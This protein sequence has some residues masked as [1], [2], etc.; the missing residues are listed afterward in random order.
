LGSDLDTRRDY[1]YTDWKDVRAFARDFSQ[2][3]V[4][5]RTLRPAV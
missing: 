3:A 2:R 4:P 5:T 1:E